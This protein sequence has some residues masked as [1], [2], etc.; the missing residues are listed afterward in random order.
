VSTEIADSAFVVFVDDFHYLAKDMQVDIGR[1]MKF[2]AEKGVKLCTASVPH[3]S[4][5][6]VRS[7]PELRGRVQAIN[8]KFWNDAELK[9]IA[10][11]GFEALNMDIAPFVLRKLI[12]EAFGSPQLMQTICLNVCLEKSVKETLPEYMRVEISDGD[13]ESI[14][15]H[16]ILWTSCR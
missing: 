10:E 13:L 5:D 16:Q 9:K 4:D 15:A 2:A 14:R 8:L 1:Q 7:N 3:R 11:A 6:V 12:A